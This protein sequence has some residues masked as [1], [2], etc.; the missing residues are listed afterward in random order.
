M[1]AFPATGP[2]DILTRP[3]LGCCDNDLKR[4]I[5]EALRHGD[6]DACIAEGATYT[7]ERCTEQF[8]GNLVGIRS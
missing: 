8:L 3:E 4:A 7:W 1:A 2:I 5:D 6:R